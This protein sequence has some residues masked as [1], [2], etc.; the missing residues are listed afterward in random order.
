MAAPAASLRYEGACVAPTANLSDDEAQQETSKITALMPERLR[1]ARS[2]NDYAG[3]YQIDQSNAITVTPDCRDLFDVCTRAVKLG[4]LLKH[5]ENSLH[6]FDG[7]QKKLK[8]QHFFLSRPAQRLAFVSHV[9]TNDRHETA[10]AMKTWVHVS[11]VVSMIWAWAAFVAFGP[12]I[13]PP[14]PLVCMPLYFWALCL[15]EKE[16]WVKQ[17]A[18]HTSASASGRVGSALIRIVPIA[19]RPIAPG[20]SAHPGSCMISRISGSTRQQSTKP[21]LL[22]VPWACSCFPTSWQRPT[23]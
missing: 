8:A 17:K 9:W 20:F 6:S 4:L 16:L 14:L 19:Y 7:K 1:G 22:C 23:N 11:I 15:Y 12:L 5:D 18:G 10:R 13:Y 2:P 21:S 3:A